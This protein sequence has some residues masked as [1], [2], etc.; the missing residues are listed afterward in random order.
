MTDDLIKIAVTNTVSGK[1]GSAP[2]NH[3]LELSKSEDLTKVRT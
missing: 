2:L 1:S 3:L